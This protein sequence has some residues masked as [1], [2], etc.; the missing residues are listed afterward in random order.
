LLF[1]EAVLD[2]LGFAAHEVAETMDDV[3]RRDQERLE[4]QVVGGITAGRTLLRGNVATPEPAPLTRPQHE[5]M[6]LN[7]AAAAAIERAA[8]GGDVAG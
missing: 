5:A 7:P 2:G 4:L 1:G 6:A 3:R 8:A